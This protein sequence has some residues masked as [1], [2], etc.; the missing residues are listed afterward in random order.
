MTIPR[1]VPKRAIWK[2]IEANDCKKWTIGFEEGSNGYRHYQI[3]LNTSNDDFFKWIKA[4]IPNSHVEKATEKWN[5]YERKSGNF[6]C[7]DDTTEI[8]QVRFGNPNPFQKKV[9]KEVRSQNVRQIDVYYDE[10][11]YHGKSW[12]VNYLWERGECHYIPP[13]LGSG[14][15][16]IQD[17][18]SKMAKERR[19]YLC[20]DIVRQQK[21]TEDLYIAM[22]VIKDGLV[23]DPRYEGET[24]NIRGTKLIVFTNT[25][26]DTK[27]LTYDRWRLHGVH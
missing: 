1:T 22:E 27:K 4:H 12:L 2:M 26:L 23:D 21:W 3:R 11:G 15:A 20:I 24:I 7:S 6:V 25:K 17:T 8:R 13:Y 5:N 19:P 10:R 16:I 9:L 14:K 18:A